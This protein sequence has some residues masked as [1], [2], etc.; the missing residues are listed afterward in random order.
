MEENYR[1]AILLQWSMVDVK[2]VRHLKRFIPLQELKALHLEHKCSN[3]EGFP[4]NITNLVLVHKLL[5]S[6][7]FQLKG[8]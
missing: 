5:Y 6:R 2:Y 4:S 3:G 1:A 8:T 7:K